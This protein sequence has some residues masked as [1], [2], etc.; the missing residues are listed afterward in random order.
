MSYLC[1]FDQNCKD[2]C[3]ENLTVLEQKIILEKFIALEINS[4]SQQLIAL[5][6]EFAKDSSG[7]SGLEK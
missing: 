6:Q 5:L 7:Q 2:F 3:E 4:K 1:S